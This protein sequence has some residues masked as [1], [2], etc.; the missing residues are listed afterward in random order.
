MHSS[1]VGAKVAAD[2]PI[3]FGLALGLLLR[4]AVVQRSYWQSSLNEC[5][6]DARP[7]LH[8]DERSQACMTTSHRLKYM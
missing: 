3:N 6:Q 8:S 4:T 2:R 5:S 7:F 1:L